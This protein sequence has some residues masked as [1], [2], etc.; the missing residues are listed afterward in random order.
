MLLGLGGRWV[1]SEFG[2]QQ[3][4]LVAFEVA[5]RYPAPAVGGADH[6]GEHEFHRGAFVAEPADHL[7]AA[8]F[9]DER[10]LSQVGG[11]DPDAMT[12]GNAVDG[13]QGVQIVLEAG[14]RGRERCR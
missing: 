5:D 13:Q 14:D 1:E 9:L 2:A 7:G 8:A 3:C 11:P 4:E 12:H 6:G 10:A